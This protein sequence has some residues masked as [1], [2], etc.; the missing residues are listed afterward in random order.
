MASSV[1]VAPVWAGLAAMYWTAT[2]PLTGGVVTYALA[3]FGEIV[4]WVRVRNRLDRWADDAMT[5]LV[6]PP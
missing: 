1:M 4:V 6:K 5:A 2:P 3:A